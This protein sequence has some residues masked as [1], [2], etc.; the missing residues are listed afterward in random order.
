MLFAL[1]YVTGMMTA[2]LVVGALAYFK[3]PVERVLRNVQV[4]LGN[5]GPRPRG[6]LLEPDDEATIAR[7]EIVAR[8]TEQGK[9]TNISE[10]QS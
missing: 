5:A 2:M 3:S 8:N 4:T 6:F 10:L 9:D 7:E 1:G